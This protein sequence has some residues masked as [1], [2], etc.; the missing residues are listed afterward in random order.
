MTELEE[1]IER[2]LVF[3]AADAD[4]LMTK[5]GA[6]VRHRRRVRR[7]ARTA[8]IV[9]ALALIAALFA[10]RPES[11]SRIGTIPTDPLALRTDR[12]IVDG[13]RP[14]AMYERPLQAGDTLEIYGQLREPLGLDRWVALSVFKPLDDQDYIAIGL[15]GAR[16]VVH[17]GVEFGIATWNDQTQVVFSDDS[18]KIVAIS[19]KGASAEAVLAA[20]R[21]LAAGPAP[22]S[23]RERAVVSGLPELVRLGPSD[24]RP[25]VALM[26]YG[27]GRFLTT[28]AMPR[29]YELRFG[30]RE[31]P[32][33]PNVADTISYREGSYVLFGDSP[34]SEPLRHPSVAE[35]NE[36][37]RTTPPFPGL[38]VD[39]NTWFAHWFGL[40]DPCRL[41]VEALAAQPGDQAWRSALRRYAQR[42]ER[43][44]LAAAARALIDRSDGSARSEAQAL[45]QRRPAVP[46][47]C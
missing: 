15:P 7:M 17:D 43:D 27:R 36:L 33:R 29:G 22:Y 42:V 18:R 31:L 2:P 5:I 26:Q 45:Q 20:A 35:W 41:M 16:S 21:T 10:N 23:L 25:Q 11:A 44:E 47:G 40:T 8:P 46:G 37:L 4:A 1:L 34:I 28:V 13:E 38:T 39:A 12:W 3:E 9:L 32:G 24:P 30:M 14:V 19:A 6:R